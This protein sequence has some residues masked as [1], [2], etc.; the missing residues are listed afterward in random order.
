MAMTS[1]RSAVS[2]RPRTLSEARHALASYTCTRWPSRMRI[3]A[4]SAIPYGTWRGS[5]SSRMT[6]LTNS[7]LA[8]H[9]FLPR[10]RRARGS[11]DQVQEL[12]ERR[13]PDCRPEEDAAL[14]AVE[15][16]ALR[17]ARHLKEDVAEPVV[18]G[19]GEP[20]LAE[21]RVL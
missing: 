19:I 15:R 20:R 18:G 6:G 16:L 10:G 14:R 21:R 17:R 9:R 5:S 13:G 8:M 2:T 4:S 12:V 7:T 1:Q 11:T 3:A